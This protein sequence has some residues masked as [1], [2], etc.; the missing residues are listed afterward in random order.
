MWTV[1]LNLSQTKVRKKNV[2]SEKKLHQKMRRLK[3]QLMGMFSGKF[4]FPL[5]ST[6]LPD[7]AAFRVLRYTF[8]F[9]LRE[10]GHAESQSGRWG[11]DAGGLR[12][13]G[14]YID[15]TW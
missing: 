7:S 10:K 12:P 5:D 3:A 4:Q 11:C 15:I 9:L 2:G 6:N 13:T 8:S 1:H 14:R